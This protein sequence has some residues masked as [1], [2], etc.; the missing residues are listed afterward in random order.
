MKANAHKKNVIKLAHPAIPESAIQ[1]A[2]DVLRSGALVQGRY[3]QEFES[4]LSDYLNAEYAVVVSSGTAALHLALL[5]SNI[6]PGDEVIVPAFTFPATANAVMLAG[7]C[8]VLVDISLDD[9]NIDPALLEEAISDRTRAI[10]PVHEFGLPANM[11]VI[12]EIAVRNNVPVIEDAA[13]ALG[14]EI[15][16][17]KIGTTGNLACFSFHP[18]K[19]ISTG[20]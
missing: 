14:A 7:A 19:A 9:C 11:R 18:R 16:G 15:D 8:P 5:V 4:A 2:A 13:C 20:T 3:V 12:Q 10:V 6:G 17:S 1:R